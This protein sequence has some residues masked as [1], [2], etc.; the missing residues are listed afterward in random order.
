M[1]RINPEIETFAKIKVVGVGGA[2]G[3]ALKR[4]IESDIK[5]VEFVAVNTDA[6]DLHHSQ[7]E[8]KVHLGKN[9]TRGLGAGMNPE[10]GR[11]SAEESKEEVYQAVNGSHMIFIT[12]GMGGGTGSGA[13]PVIAQAAKESGALTVAVVTKPFM[14]EG[15]QRKRI[16]EA[17]FEELKKNVD[18]IITI[19]NDKILNIIDRNT[20]V[21]EAFSMIDDVLRQGVQGISDLITTPGLV[22][23]DFADVSAIMKNAGS[24]LMGIGSAAGENRAVTAAKIAINSPL[25]D[26]SIKGAKGVLFNVTGGK[27]LSMAEI[28]DA[29][30]VIIESIDPDAQV[31]FGA[32]INDKLNEGEVQ[33]TVIATGF[34]QKEDKPKISVLQDKEQ[35]ST[36]DEMKKIAEEQELKQ[37]E[38]S[39]QKEIELKKDEFIKNVDSDLE[40]EFELPAFIRNKLGKK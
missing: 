32:V 29:A 26:V 36:Q 37:Q 16:A 8:H 12:A 33:V 6:Q 11:K 30:N 9:L 17:A 3:N 38:E 21:L 19:P 13:S 18:T 10:V 40:D 1:A 39:R 28:N 20:P 31:I 5:G 22:N 34:D 4:M 15:V 2:G 25:L 35:S 14:F 7:A 23:V 27:D 24:A